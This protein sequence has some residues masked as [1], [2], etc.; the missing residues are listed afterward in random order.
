MTPL[1]TTAGLTNTLDHL[2]W[3]G[4]GGGPLIPIES[5][6]KLSLKYLSAPHKLW[7][8]GRLPAKI[9]AE[10]DFCGAFAIPQRR[11]N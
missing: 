6:I 11:G 1:K 2:D 5:V 10:T 9:G 7:E 8:S 3:A 4:Q